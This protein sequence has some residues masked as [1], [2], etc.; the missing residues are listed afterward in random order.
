MNN[1]FKPDV[2]TL[3]KRITEEASLPDT[4]KGMVYK[5]SRQQLV[6]LYMY[7]SELKRTNVELVDKIR[8]LNSKDTND[9]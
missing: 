9:V 8:Q 1:K 3:I 7:L 6:E 5:F 2:P 4:E